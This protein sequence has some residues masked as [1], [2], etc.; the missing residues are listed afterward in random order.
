M[1]KFG[2]ST[3]P[4]GTTVDTEWYLSQYPDVKAGIE[5]GKFKSAYQHFIENG[6]REGRVPTKFTFDEA[7]YLAT[8]PDVAQAIKSGAAKSAYDH[9]LQNGYGEGRKPNAKA[10]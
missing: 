6:Y 4:F 8:Y 5:S 9:F 10:K 3:P 7:W 2:P 1:R